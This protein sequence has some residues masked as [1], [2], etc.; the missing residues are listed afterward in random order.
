[1]QTHGCKVRVASVLTAASLHGAPAA[2]GSKNQPRPVHTALLPRR[3][4]Q[5]TGRRP[6]TDP[7]LIGHART[8]HA[9]IALPTRPPARSSSRA[10]A[11]GSAL[12]PSLLPKRYDV[13]TSTLDSCGSRDGPG[14]CQALH[15]W[16]GPVGVRV[17]AR[18]NIC[19]QDQAVS[20]RTAGSCVWHVT[21]SQSCSFRTPPLP[22]AWSRPLRPPSWWWPPPGEPAHHAA[23]AHSGVVGGVG[24]RPLSTAKH[25]Q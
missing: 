11:T 20:R 7:N 13:M 15:E 10:L 25:R 18:S 1:M 3:Q 16:Q 6:G 22:A 21:R 2:V 19:Q 5:H 9:S 24:G 17:V 4:G 14:W 12:A 23:H 8:M